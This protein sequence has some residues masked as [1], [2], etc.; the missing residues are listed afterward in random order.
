MK[1]AWCLYGQP[2]NFEDG[3]NNINKFINNENNK[4]HK[5]DFYLHCWFDKKFVNKYYTHSYRNISLNDLLITANTD[6]RILELYKPIDFIFEE[7]KIF[8]SEYLKDTI[9]D[10]NTHN[11]IIK[12]NYSNVLSSLYSKYKVCEILNKHIHDTNNYD[13]IISTRFD[14]LNE[15]IIDIETLDKSKLNIIC[16]DESRIIIN[17]SFI[18]TNLAIFNKYSNTINNLHKL[19]NNKYIIDKCN[20]YSKSVEFV[21]ENILLMNLL[22]YYDN[23][24]EN[25]I[26]YRKDMLN[27]LK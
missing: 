22:Y 9:V 8:N 21:P 16:L 12:N 7:P 25:I 15:F 18:I 14:Y 27:F 2:R 20:N 6:T 4:K 23:S 1:I 17:D 11:Q 19:I 10:I 13:L 26:M 24:I 3:Y 5:F